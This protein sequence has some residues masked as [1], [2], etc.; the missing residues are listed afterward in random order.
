MLLLPLA[1]GPANNAAVHPG[2]ALWDIN[3]TC[4]S[5]HGVAGEGGYGPDL[6]GHKLTSAQFLRAV[7]KPWGMMPTYVADKNFNDQE[8]AQIADY[9]AGLPRV[10]EPAPWR[11]PIPPNASPGQALQIS[12]GCGQCHGVAMATP[13][14]DGGGEGADFE[15]F[16]GM[17]YNH[18]VAMCQNR[19]VTECGRDRLRMGNYSTLRLPEVALRQIWNFMTVET[20]LLVPVAGQITSAAPASGGVTFTLKLRNEGLAGKGLTAENLNIA[21]SLAPGMTVSG[22]TGGGYQGIRRDAAAN[23]DTAVWQ[24]PRLAPGEERTYT[25]TVS[26]SAA[27]GITGGKVVWAKPAL[28]DGSSDQLVLAAPRAAQNR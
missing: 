26:G 17:V 16:K 25:V 21:L 20:G 18:T 15:W 8:I 12:Y 6:A 14:R 1:Q 23:A 27:A 13:R 7:R 3:N 22:T 28:G 9:L 19:V 11:T 5:C 10:A 4:R 2:K 24:L